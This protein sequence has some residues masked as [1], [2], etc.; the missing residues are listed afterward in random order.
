MLVHDLELPRICLSTEIDKMLQELE[1]TVSKANQ[2]T[3]G[4]FTAFQAIDHATELSR[5]SPD[6]YEGCSVST[7]IRPLH[8]SPPRPSSGSVYI[9]SAAAELMHNYIHIVSNVLQPVHHPKNPYRSIYAPQAMATG[10]IVVG[11]GEKPSHSGVALSHGLLAVSAFYLH[12]LHQEDRHYDKIARLHRM[13][14]IS[15]LK[16]ALLMGEETSGGLTALL[17]MLSLVSIDLMEGGMTEFWIHLDGCEKLKA[18]LRD[19]GMRSSRHTQLT[20]I[21]SFMNMLSQS[22]APYTIPKLSFGGS[23]SLGE[24]LKSSPFLP[25][26]HTLEFTYGATATLA[27]YL[28]LTISLSQS[29]AYFEVNDLPP[30]PNLQKTCTT[31]FNAISSWS[32]CQETFASLSET[33]YETRSLITCYATAFH[34]AAMIYFHTILRYPASHSNMKTYNQICVSNLLA[35][36]A[37]KLADHAKKSWNVMAPIVWPGF[38]AACEASASERFLWRKW[39]TVTQKYCIGSIETLWAVVQEVWKESDEG[40]IEQP[41]WRD[42]LRR[43]GKRVMSGG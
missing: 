38:I 37:L 5:V 11:I 13:K 22:T 36:E 31:L 2:G 25:D 29:F 17:A 16:S 40:A 6:L 7:D 8:T 18:S 32:I 20:S 33:D 42:V 28:Y 4:P 30:P 35:A 43:R 34:A 9:D 3:V 21:C 15:N 23:E 41:G 14:A 27:S 24:L 26:N 10:H 19:P 12:R 39:W 1:E